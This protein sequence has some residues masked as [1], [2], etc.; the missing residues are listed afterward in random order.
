MK[1]TIQILSVLFLASLVIV[2]CRKE[3]EEEPS[4]VIASFQY[5]I[6]PSDW[7]E[8]IFSNFSQNA[9]SY[10]WDFGDGNSSTEQSP[11]HT[12]VEGGEYEVT[13]TATGAA[14]SASKTE[15]VMVVDPNTAALFLAGESGKVWHL[16][17]QEIALGIGP[18]I[19][20]NQWW[21][22]GG[23]TP[24]GDR[25]CILDDSY[26]FNPDGT[27]EKNTEGTLFVDA[28]ANGGWLGDT[29][30]C[31]GEMDTG[32]FTGPNGEDLSAFANGGSYTYDFN[33]ADNTITIDGF[34]AYIGLCNKTETGDNYIPVGSKTYTIFNMGTGDI[35]DT[36]NIAIAALD[37][38]F[39]WNFHLLSYHN[40]ADLPPLPTAM[41][42]ANFSYVKDGNTVTF[43]NT[44]TNA[45]SYMWDF[46]DGATSTETSP[47][48]TYAGDGD[49]TV[50][51]TATDDNAMSDEAS[52]IVSISSAVFT[53]AEISSAS[54]KV[55]KLDGEAS[56][57]VGPCQ[58]CNDYWGG[59]D[60]AGVIE[61][62]CQLDDEFIFYD[63]GT[64]EIDTQGQV[65]VENFLGGANECIDESML[66][67]PFDAF[68]SGTHSFTADA[69]EV[70]VNGLGAYI[71][72]NKPFNG[73]EL[74]GD[75]SGSPASSI[76]YEVL[77]YTANDGTERLTI[78]VDYGETP[79][80][81]YWT[82][83]MISVE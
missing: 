19:G 43:E 10:V 42:T 69:N 34:G 71:G 40:P 63:D 37:G 39:A 16:N 79:G 47:V 29:E 48:H 27:F 15:T 3:P 74:A 57:I 68:A 18:S 76:T 67:S 56:Y 13:L 26:T 17:R 46:G 24:L 2:S 35:A 6:S 25:P 20:D 77:E 82:I 9:T 65:W 72:W 45:T 7:A 36:L 51:L 28:N 80:A 78:T 70:T 30:S 52:Q 66:M 31:Y 62:A 53:G 41:P 1:K 38:S 83:R 32:V 58:G 12:Y 55:W 21:S 44:S 50:T 22:F 64:M 54:G 23:V 81:D 11:S 4:Q 60:A 8:V 59:I 33:T 73:G 49:Y 14:G 61:R 5:E 75:A